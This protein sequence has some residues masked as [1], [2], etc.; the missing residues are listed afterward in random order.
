MKTLNRRKFVSSLAAIPAIS[1]SSLSTPSGVNV[2]HAS[3]E[4]RHL[5][6]VH[7]AWHGAWAW[8]RVAPLLE[9]EGFNVSMLDL[10]GLGANSHRQSPEIGMHVHGQDILNHL[11][12]NDMWDVVVVGHSYG[13]SPLSQAVANDQEGRISHAVWLDAF[14]PGEGEAVATFQDEATQTAFAQAVA[15]GAMIPPRPP[16]EWEHIWGLVGEPAEFSA[17]RLSP[18]SARCFTETVQGDP[19][20]SEIRRTYIQAAQNENPIFRN[21]LAQARENPKFEAAEV[22]GHHNV[23]VLDPPTMRDALVAA[24]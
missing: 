12:Y 14:L 21:F 20:S 22:D 9:A 3:D 19:F 17:P 18:M 13:G 6:L 23:M 11:Y 16:E 15:E 4:R 2:L 7:G 5:C 10:S 8:V 1:L 24:I